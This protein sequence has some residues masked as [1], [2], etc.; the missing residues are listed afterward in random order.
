MLKI[1]LVYYILEKVYFLGKLSLQK[2]TKFIFT[3]Y[4]SSRG[5]FIESYPGMKLL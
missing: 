4:F 1:L 2:I 5:G 3:E